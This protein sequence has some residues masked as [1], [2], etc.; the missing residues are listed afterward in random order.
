MRGHVHHPIVVLV[1]QRNR[2]GHGWRQRRTGDMSRLDSLRN[3][4]LHVLNDVVLSD[5]GD[6]HIGHFLQL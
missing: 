1:N 3:R 4:D 6:P 2:R 5:Q